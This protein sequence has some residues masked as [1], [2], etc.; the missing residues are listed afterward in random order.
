MMAF[1]YSLDGEDVNCSSDRHWT[2]HRAFAMRDMKKL[3]KDRNLSIG[4]LAQ[5]PTGDGCEATFD[6]VEF[7][8]VELKDL[9]DGS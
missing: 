8:E 9:R 7:R 6:E 1:H 5:A 4:F 3:G 2:L